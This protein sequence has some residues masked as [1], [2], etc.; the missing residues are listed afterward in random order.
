PATYRRRWQALRPTHDPKG[1][2]HDVRARPGG[3]PACGNAHIG[4]DVLGSRDPAD[5][6]N[7]HGGC[8]R[9]RFVRK[10][11][12]LLGADDGGDDVAGR[13]AGGREARSSPIDA[14]VRRLVPGRLDAGW[15][16]RLC[17]VPATWAVRGWGVDGCGRTLRADVVQACVPPP[18][19]GASAL[20]LRA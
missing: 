14:A 19:P 12:R 8:D 17:G 3:S 1:S 2:P 9:A 16:S 7:G 4:S 6:W 18:L 13:G 11:H 20:G 10:L 5:E 15:P